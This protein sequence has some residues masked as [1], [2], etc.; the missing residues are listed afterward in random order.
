MQYIHSQ[1]RQEL[2]MQID[3]L[4]VEGK[5]YGFSGCHRYEVRLGACYSNLCLHQSSSKLR[6][7]YQIRLASPVMTVCGFEMMACIPGMPKA[8]A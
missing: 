2:W 5:Y 4:L 6:S 7:K 3:I 8:R 1:E